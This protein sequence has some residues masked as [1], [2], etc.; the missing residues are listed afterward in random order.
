MNAGGPLGQL[1]ACFVL[2]VEDSL[3]SIFQALHDAALIQQS[4]GGTGYDFSRLRAS[5]RRR[6]SATG[7]IASGPVSFMRVFDASIETIRQ[8]GR[9]RGRQ[10]G[11]APRLASRTSSSSSPRSASRACSSN[12]NL[13]VAIP[14]AFVEAVRTGRAWELRNPRDGAP[15]RRIDANE[16]LDAIAA[17]AWE[18]GDPGLVFRDRINRDNPTPELGA[19]TATNPCGEV[20]L[21][22][23]EACMLGSIDVSKHTGPRGMDWERLA[24]ML[25]PSASASWTTAWRPA[26]SRWR[27]SERSCGPTARSGSA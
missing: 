6:R 17:S 5:G 15:V 2:P 13:S 12:F 26:A 20:P 1:A 27:A 8:G 9:R 21:L 14:D 18:T 11:G 25:S 3:D 7:G 19:I 23:Y 10:H 4:G 16:L 22:P 24:A